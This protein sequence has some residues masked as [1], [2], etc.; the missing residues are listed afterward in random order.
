MCGCPPGREGRAPATKLR[1]G[2]A[3]C[4]GD[5]WPVGSGG[6]E[7]PE[8]PGLGTSWGVLAPVKGF[9]ALRNGVLAGLVE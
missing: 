7:N 9:L 1:P 5:G 4:A 2:A 8:S 3:V 6:G